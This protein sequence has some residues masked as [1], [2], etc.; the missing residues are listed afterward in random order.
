[1]TTIEKAHLKNIVKEILREDKSLLKEAIKEIFNE[2]EEQTLRD[3]LATKNNSKA[4]NA[5]DEEWERIIKLP[6]I[7]P[8]IDNMVFNELLIQTSTHYKKVWEALA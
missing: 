7:S 1:M 8:L 2:D 4:S 5:F 6:D 3:T